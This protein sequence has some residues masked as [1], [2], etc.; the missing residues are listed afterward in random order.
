ME[1]PA[2][3]EPATPSLPSMVGPFGGQR[4]TSLRSTEPQVA[5]RIEDREMGCCE[6]VCGAAAGKSLARIQVGCPV[7]AGLRDVHVRGSGNGSKPVELL[8]RVIGPEVGFEPTPSDYESESLRPAGAIASCSG[9]SRQRGRPLSALL[10][11]R[12]MAGGMTKRM[13]SLPS[14]DRTPGPPTAL[15]EAQGVDCSRS[16]SGACGTCHLLAGRSLPPQPPTR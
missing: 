8:E 3:I 9:C 6:A 15:P 5:G 10:T 12:V 1:P 16:S 2:G 7:V 4:G 13:T 14:S 11:C